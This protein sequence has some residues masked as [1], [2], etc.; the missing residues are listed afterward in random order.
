MLSSFGILGGLGTAMAFVGVV[1]TV[2]G[3]A[4]RERPNGLTIAIVGL[5]VIGLG[6]ALLSIAMLMPGAR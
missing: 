6:I 3:V 4:T 2:Y 5:P 1:L